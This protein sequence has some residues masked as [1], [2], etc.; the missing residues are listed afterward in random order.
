MTGW[1]KRFAVTLPGLLAS[2]LAVAQTTAEI[3]TMRKGINEQRSEV[4]RGYQAGKAAC[5]QLF[6]VNDC[7]LQVQKNRSTALAE[8]KRQEVVLNDEERKRKVAAQVRKLDERSS[9]EAQQNAADRRASR[10]E[11]A[12]S[13]QQRNADRQLVRTPSADG[14]A[15]S[16]T[17]RQRGD[18]PVA[19]PPK[20]S[21]PRLVAS[22]DTAQ[23]QQ[24]FSRK[25]QDAAARKADLERTRRE[26][27]Q[28]L[29]QPLP[30]TGASPTPLAEQLV[31]PR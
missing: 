14:R 11:A 8:L 17:D 6:S 21:P 27:T 29:S 4:E 9:A 20:T 23:S 26:R 10:M 5:Y 12:T 3:A 18:K 13:V 28:P 30:P 19:R 15:D 31:A 25:Q 24:S 7:L 1:I 16:D 2:I 22:P